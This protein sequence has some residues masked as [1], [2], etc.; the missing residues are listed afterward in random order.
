VKTTGFRLMVEA[1][2]LKWRLPGRNVARAAF[3]RV[4]TARTI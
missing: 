1:P 3:V 4:T 2:K